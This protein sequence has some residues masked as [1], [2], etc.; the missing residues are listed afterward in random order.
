V[1]KTTK[2]ADGSVK[3]ESEA[4]LKCKRR[5]VWADKLSTLEW[6]HHIPEGGEGQ[7]LWGGETGETGLERKGSEFNRELLQ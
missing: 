7:S 4:R 6:A 3:R 1:W 2:R 5:F